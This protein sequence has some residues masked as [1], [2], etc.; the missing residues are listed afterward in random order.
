MACIKTI[1]PV[2]GYIKDCNNSRFIMPVLQELWLSVEFI[3]PES[4]KK[5]EIFKDIRVDYT[6]M[7]PEN[8]M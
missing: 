7:I 3:V 2:T 5:R 8:K 1:I 6:V 4:K